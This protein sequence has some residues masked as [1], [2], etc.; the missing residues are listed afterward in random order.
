M[1]AI[2]SSKEVLLELGEVISQMEDQDYSRPL[3][4]FSNSSI[5]MHVRHVLEFY[6]CLF[7]QGSELNYDK[8]QRD[9]TIQSS[10]ERAKEVI[11]HI[12]M[13]LNTLTEEN[14]NE[15]ILLSDIEDNAPISTSLSRELHYNFEH[16]IHHS[17]L[18]KIGI[19]SLDKGIVISDRFGVAP[20]TLRYQN[21]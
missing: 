9:L 12:V 3:V 2:N 7:E 16:T 1:N 8:R 13:K 21:R 14:L 15:P 5:G 20:S 11:T 18:L 4:I 6:Q 10:I 19:L 17:A